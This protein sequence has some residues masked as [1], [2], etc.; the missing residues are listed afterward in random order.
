MSFICIFLRLMRRKNQQERSGGDKVMWMILKNCGGPPRQEGS[1]S[2]FKYYM[3]GANGG[4][5]KLR[6][7]YE[8]L[9]F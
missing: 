2:F 5:I 1:Y 7:K 4:L 6:H 8:K 9:N 3:E